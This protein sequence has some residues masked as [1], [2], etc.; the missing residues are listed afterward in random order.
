MYEWIFICGILFAFY[1]AWGI[2]ANDC[3]NSFA[4]SVGA[5]VLTLK[6]AILVAAIFEFSGAVFMGSH[7]TNTVRK[8]IVDL[9]IFKDNPGA[10][11]YGMLCA[12]LASAIW[13]TIATYLKLPVSTTHS[14]IGAIV[15]FSLAY[16]GHNAVNWGKIYLVVASWVASPLISGVFAGLLF[17]IIN[18][19][20][21]QSN[22]SYQYTQRIFPLLTFFTFFINSLFIIYKGSPQL[23]LDETELW[24]ALLSAVL[25]GVATGLMAQFLY[26]PYVTRK[27]KL[28]DTLNNANASAGDGASAETNIDDLEKNKTESYI[29]AITTQIDNENNNSK[30]FIYND[31]ENIE[32]NIKNSKELVKS[33][34]EKKYQ[35]ELDK[36]YK[37]SDRIDEKSERLCSWVQI[38]TAC[39][40]S[41][42][43]GSNDV[44]NAIAPLA[45]IYHI[46]QYYDVEKKS[47]VPIW[48]L[49]LGGVGIVIG[50]STWGYKII[51]RIGREL[52]KISPSRGFIIELS[53]ALTIIMASRVEIPV[54]TTHCQVGS[55]IG[56]GL[57]G[58]IKNIQWSLV[59][60]I[61]FS[62]LV[63]LPITGFLSAGFFS[64]GYYSPNSHSTIVD[65]IFNGSVFNDSGFNS[66]GFNGS[67]IV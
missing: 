54:S 49:I 46:Y 15:G 39:F 16:G 4:T 64:Y 62:W 37:N 66:S 8:K 2:G 44:A 7:V 26:L 30:D 47:D 40:S 59:N 27:M 53:A 12:D 52:T 45:T 55:I 1:N 57:V 21:F 13:L 67:G 61:I 33:L 65:N 5:K 6:Q 25:V 42:A 41:F 29:E 38:I 60:K 10:L 19:F 17:F 22:R 28:E 32:T 58:G 34:E 14:I 23:K 18:R 35:D 50:L 56:C 51:D 36:L 43:H 9:D 24:V 48:I 11:M 63:T 31:T 3:A 20:I